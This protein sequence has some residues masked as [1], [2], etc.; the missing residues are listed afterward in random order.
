VAYKVVKLKK[1]HSMK[2]AILKEKAL[3]ETRV[4]ITPDVA[5]RFV[6]DGFEVYIEKNAG[7][8]AGFLD[9]QYVDAGAKVS[10][11]PLE[12]VSDADVILKVQPTPLDDKINEIAFAKK[13]AT[14]IAFLSPYNNKFLSQ[15]YAEQGLTALAMELVPR[16]TKA[17][18]MDALSSQSN[19]AG[20][21]AVIEASYYFKRAVPMFMTA[22]GTVTA[23]KV[24]V[25]GAGV[26]GLQAAA[27]AKRLGSIVYAYDIRAVAKE[28]VE[29]VGAKFIQLEDAKNFESKGGYAGEVTQEY[30]KKQEELI[31]EYV[32][33]VDIVIS[34]A[35]I[36]GKAAPKLIT[37]AMVASMAPGSVIVD[38]ATSTGGNVDGSEKDQIV[39]VG[40]VKIIGHSN[41]AMS[42]P[43]DASKLYARNLYNLV[44][45]AFADGKL[46]V[47]DEIVSKML[48]SYKGKEMGGIVG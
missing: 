5:K 19:L 26:A 20:Y 25:L 6:R 35:Q 39:D 24:L 45:H 11:V 27:T 16:V 47:E 31:A 7:L 4:A 43:S 22:A 28:Q 40:N 9:D 3:G 41:L 8:M 34:T 48:L 30:M 37:K 18:S 13:G 33:K 14:I 17:Q 23:A 36:P 32:K 29:S 10:G 38:L 15:T 12:I 21:R 1:H 46:K 42:V 2:I 44:I